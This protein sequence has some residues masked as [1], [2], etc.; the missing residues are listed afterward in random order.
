[1]LQAG[2]APASV[3]PCGVNRRLNALLSLIKLPKR[4]VDGRSR[5]YISPLERAALSLS[6]TTNGQDWIRTNISHHPFGWL[7]GALS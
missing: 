2:L 1:M 6:Y 3:L 7:P 4:M 5:T